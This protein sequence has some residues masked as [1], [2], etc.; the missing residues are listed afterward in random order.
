VRVGLIGAGR[1]VE[2]VHLPLLRRMR[3]VS[4]V[5]LFDPARERAEALASKFGLPRVCRTLGELLELGP[6]AVLVASPNHLHAA[7]SIA[8]LEAGADVL[9]EKPLATSAA[10]AELMLEATRRTGRSLMVAFTNRFRPEVV[11]LRRAVGEGRLGRVGAVRCGWL[12][13]QGVP[14]VGTWFTSR[15]SAGGGALTDI[16]SHLVDLAVWLSG[17]REVSEACCLLERP[18]GGGAQ[19]SWYSPAERPAAGVSDVE[20]GA[21]GFAVLGGPAAE[22][23][24]QREAQESRHVSL[25]VEASWAGAVPYDRTYLH[26]YGEHGSAR[27]ETLFGLSPSAERPEYVLRVWEQRRGLLSETSDVRDALAPYRAQWRFFLDSLP[28][29][30]RLRPMLQDAVAT[31]RVVEALYLAARRFTRA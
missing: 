12:R 28:D 9:C 26:L 3:D 14:G 27:L 8:A 30:D 21:S 25:F 18:S 6:A 4:P 29:P 19:A 2:R 7:Q 16:G 1:I 20:V 13:R 24:E 11:A 15:E 22:A 10:D 17:R 5:G 23:R 31:V